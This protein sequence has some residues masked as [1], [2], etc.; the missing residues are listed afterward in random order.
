MATTGT[1]QLTLHNYAGTTH[2]VIDI[3]GY[4]TTQRSRCR[5]TYAITPCRVVDT[6]GR[7]AHWPPAPHGRGR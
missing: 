6:R 5:R 3:Q 2:Y 7:S 1:K 4:F